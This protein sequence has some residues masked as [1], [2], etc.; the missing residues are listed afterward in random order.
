MW[1]RGQSGSVPVEL[2]RDPA[3]RA[4]IGREPV[5]G[6]GQVDVGGDAGRH[7]VAATE[8]PPEPGQ[9]VRQPGDDIERAAEHRGPGPGECP[10]VVDDQFD[11]VA[12]KVDLA[13]ARVRLARDPGTMNGVVR[14]QGRRPDR[15][16]VVVPVVYNLDRGQSRPD[17]L[18]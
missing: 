5:A 15:L 12:G 10:L 4:E 17:E 6:P 16:P 9:F 1:T 13:P 8:P 11:R 14:E 7:A 3:E 2:E 18:A